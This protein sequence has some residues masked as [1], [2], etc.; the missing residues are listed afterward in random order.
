M[1]SRAVAESTETGCR[2]SIDNDKIFA[3]PDSPGSLLVVTDVETIERVAGWL[4]ESSYTV[5]LTG[6]GISTESGIPDFRGP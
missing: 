3:F 6:A 1:A 5:V 4:R 2:S